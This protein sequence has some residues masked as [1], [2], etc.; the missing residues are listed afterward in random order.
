[1]EHGCADCH[2]DIEEGPH[3]APIRRGECD[4]GF[5]KTVAGPLRSYPKIRQWWNAV[6]DPITFIHDPATAE[7]IEHG[8][9]ELSAGRKVC[10]LDRDVGDHATV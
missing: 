2:G 8:I 9:V 4:M 10:A 5:S 3:G 1:V 6:A 7:H